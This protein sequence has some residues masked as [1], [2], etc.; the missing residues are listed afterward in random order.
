MDL[1]GY[2]HQLEY[3]RE[4]AKGH[5]K[6]EY[7]ELAD[8]M[9]FILEHRAER[10]QAWTVRYA[11]ACAQDFLERRGVPSGTFLVTVYRLFPG[12]R[13]HVITVRMNWEKAG[14]VP[15][16]KVIAKPTIRT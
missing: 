5:R 1:Q 15:L 6:H 3:H 7:T 10:R 13:K 8:D 12:E 4:L 9:G 16:E 11:T 14:H 2:P